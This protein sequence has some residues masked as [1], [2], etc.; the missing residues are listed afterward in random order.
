M[1][2]KPLLILAATLLMSSLAGGAVA[3]EMQM[4]YVRLA[5]LE[6]DPTQLE[7]FKAAATEEIEA[8][9]RVEPGVLALYA[10]YVKDHPDQV[11]VFEMYTDADAYRAH[12][13][14]AHFKKFAATTKDMVKF[15]KLMDG[16]PISLSAKA[17]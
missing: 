2:A 11:R 16:I 14:T 3:K 4:P 7:S 13:E 17:K 8:S 12:L 5:E 6:I 10:V 9:V 1:K 15:R